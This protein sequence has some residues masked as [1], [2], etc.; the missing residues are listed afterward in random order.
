[1]KLWA[2]PGWSLRSKLITAGVLV[3]LVASA[4]LMIGSE[5]LLQRSLIEQANENVRQ[6]TVVLD[7]TMAAPLAQRDYATLQ[8]TLDLIRRDEAISYLVL[9]DHRDKQVAASGWNTARPLPARDGADID[10][11]RDDATQHVA[12]QLEVAGQPLGRLDLGLSMAGLRKT[13][14]DFRQQG[15]AI[16]AAALA[17]SV[18]ILTTVSWMITRHLAYLAGASQRVADGDFE[19]TM[20]TASNDE[21]GRLGASFN[22]MTRT[23]RQRMAALQESEG[24]QRRH[25]SAAR[26]EQARLTTLLSA[27]RSGIL[28]VDAHSKI[29]YANEQFCRIWGLPTIPPGQNLA[30]IVP[31]LSSQIAPADAAHLQ[32]MFAV[33]TEEEGANQELHML[34]NRIVVQHM[35]PVIEGSSRNGCIWFHTDITQ[36]RQTQ[37]RAQQALHDPLTGLFNRRALYEFLQS[38]IALVDL[39]RSELTLMFIDLDDFKAI[40]DAGG[41]HAGDEL[42]ITVGQA[43][44]GQLRA[45]QI[46]ARL[47]GDE[48][49]VLC[50][51][52]GTEMAGAIAERLVVAVAGLSIPIGARSLRVGCSIG[53]AGYPSDALTQDHLV[54]CADAAMYLAKRQGKNRWARHQ[55]A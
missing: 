3:Q 1:M 26:E 9:W 55:P 54:S 20:P 22:V 16:A 7:Q 41:H 39:E 21:I 4:L 34:D 6:L 18:L 50:P 23:L 47:G 51:G 17:L 11:D 46:V 48:F 19:V 33:N 40:N 45:G 15:L 10:L 25:L 24:Q 38:A 53:V 14:A 27:M 52:I 37:Q 29:I 43:I 42:L 8:Q 32:L 36:E 44:A 35:Q 5:R 31:R 13:R 28:F 12:V 49:A 30:D 2:L